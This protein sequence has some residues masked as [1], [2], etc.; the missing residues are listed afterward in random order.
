MR[1]E[2]GW[3]VEGGLKLSKNEQRARTGPRTYVVLVCA[4]PYVV[5]VSIAC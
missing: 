3:R 2:G 5:E 4:E 1:R